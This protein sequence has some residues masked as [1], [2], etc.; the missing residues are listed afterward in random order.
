MI[1]SI[2]R[3]SFRSVFSSGDVC[4][5]AV[6]RSELVEADPSVVKGQPDLARA[7][8]DV[9]AFYVIHDLFPNVFVHLL[10]PVSVFLQ[11]AMYFSRSLRCT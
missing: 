5:P 7:E 4:I 6:P 1:L 9:L 2:G 11:P 3:F 8:P 10:P